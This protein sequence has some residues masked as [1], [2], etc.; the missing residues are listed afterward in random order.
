MVKLKKVFAAAIAATLAAPTSVFAEEVGEAVGTYTTTDATIDQTKLGSIV[1]AKYLSNDGASID[2][3]GVAYAEEND[4][5]VGAIRELT[6]NDSIMPEKG[7]KFRLLKVADIEQVTET[8]NRLGITGTYYTNFDEDFFDIMNSYLGADALKASDSTR[9]TDGRADSSA[10]S[11][12]DDH[13]E[14]DELNAKMMQVIRSAALADGSE[15]VTGEVALN[16]YVR[17]HALQ[18]GVCM[19]FD[20]TDEDGITEIGNLPLGLYLICEIDYEHKA[21]S[22]HDGYWERVDDGIDDA[23]TGDI[24][25]TEDA[26]N[27]NNGIYAGGQPAGGSTYA[28]IASPASPF[29]VSIP[30]T[31]IATITGEDGV[32]HQ[33]GTVWQYDVV[34][35]PKNG[36]INIHKDIVTNDFAGYDIGGTHF[37][38]NDG[39]DIAEDKTLCDFRQT[40]YDSLPNDPLTPDSALDG[41]HKNG[42]VHQIDAN[43]GDTITQVVSADVPVLVDDI[44]DE[45]DGANRDNAFRKHNKTYKI[46]DR[47]TK[48]LHLIDHNSFLVTLSAGVWNDYANATVLEEGTDYTLTFA[49]DYMSY[50]LEMTE[51]GLHKMDDLSTASYLYIKYDVELTNDALIGTDT[52]G[53][54]R[55]T[56]KASPAT[57]EDLSTSNMGTTLAI[58]E[59]KTDTAYLSADNVEHPDATNQNT[60]MLTYATDRTMEHDYYSNTTKVFTY[61]IDLTKMFTDGTQGYISKNSAERTSFQFKDVKFTVRGSVQEGSIDSLKPEYSEGYEDLIFVRVGD[62]QY[63]IWD[64]FTDGGLY[65]GTTDILDQ[66]A[67]EKTITKFVTP[68]SETGLLTLRGLDARTYE[69]TE[70]ATAQ[71]RNLMASKFYCEIIAPVVNDVTLEDGSVDHA[72]VWSGEKPAAAELEKYDLASFTTNMERMDYGRVPFVVQNNEIIKILKTGGTGIVGL[73][74]TGTAMMSG[75]VAFLAKKKKE[76]DEA[77]IEA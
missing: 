61:E 2:A 51:E 20:E 3:E 67:A 13:F 76:E 27:E 52:Y 33:P 41:Q 9:V 53:T 21:L 71:G 15:S 70:V 32:V 8:E 64:P 31:N 48:G 44:D 25:D 62:G 72:Y 23:L 5:L 69:F 7:V 58:D 59:N 11:E 74:V 66:P 17:M 29:L 49:E 10:A 30:M 1:L 19:D 63:R 26:G 75:C 56:T 60:A 12:I 14:S 6:G 4:Q 18:E 22:K 65:D 42:L 68:N 46:T 28:D 34:V 43:I 73:V 55:I 24:G 47:M 77:E 50:V 35:Y 36:T 37:A 40:N 54:Q 57:E 16:R 39:N 38:G 45:F